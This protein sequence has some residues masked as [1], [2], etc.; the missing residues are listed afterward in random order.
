MRN[1]DSTSIRKPS[2]RQ[3]DDITD[4]N[5]KT[6]SNRQFNS[7]STLERKRLFKEY[8]TKI[9]DNLKTKKKITDMEKEYD[10]YGDKMTFNEGWDS[11][12][13]M[14]T[15]RISTLNINGI[16]KNLDWLEWE[17]LL[18]K[19]K[20]LQIDCMGITEPN[21]NFNNNKVMLSLYEKMKALDRHM[22][23]TVSCSN[24][25]NSMEKSGVEQQLF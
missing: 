9:K 3:E 11:G 20:N 19:S 13:D 7:I 6:D 17:I 15:F 12:L 5:V 8:D 22:Q 23:V 1:R 24:Q 4:D 10:W 18:D 25:L 2:G 14:N 21:I 16:S